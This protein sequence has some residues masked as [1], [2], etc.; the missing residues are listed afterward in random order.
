MVISARQCSDPAEVRAR[1]HVAAKYVERAKTIKSEA[2][3]DIASSLRA[4][5]IKR[6]RELATAEERWSAVKPAY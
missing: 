4:D 2:E 5:R 6:D 3:P 1:L